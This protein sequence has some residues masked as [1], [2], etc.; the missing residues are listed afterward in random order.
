MGSADMVQRE[1]E[2]QPLLFYRMRDFWRLLLPWMF[3]FALRDY[4][5][6]LV[7]V[8]TWLNQCNIKDVFH[9]NL[10]C[11]L[12]L[13]SLAEASLRQYCGFYAVIGRVL[14]T[15]VYSQH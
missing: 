3:P 7:D 1:G 15:V 9:C 12:G 8:A 11:F 4:P 2:C 10:N 5:A 6:I 13:L 14:C